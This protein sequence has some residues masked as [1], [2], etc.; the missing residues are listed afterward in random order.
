MD[1][2]LAQRM[3]PQTINEVLGQQTLI[4]PHGFLRRCI[5]TDSLVSMVLYGPSGTGKTTIAK[6]LGNDMKMPVIALNA[7][8]TSKADMV[9]A[10]QQAADNFP[11]MVIIDEIHRLPKDKQDLLLPYLESGDFFMVGTTTANPYISLNPAL[12]SR[13]QILEVKPLSP[14][15]ILTGLKRA[16]ASPVGLKNNRKFDEQ[17]LIS[18]AKM[19]GGDLRFAYNLLETLALYYPAGHLITED[20]LKSVRSVPNFLSDKDED[21]HYN[22]VSGLQKS[23]RGSQVDAALFYLAKLLQGGDLEG[24]IRRLLV[25]AYEDVG[26]ANPQAV[27]RCYHACQVAR[28]VGMPEAQIPL[29]FTVVDLALSPKS[30]SSCLAIETAMSTITDAPV[31]VREY[32]KLHPVGLSKA[33][34]YPYDRPD[35]WPKLEYMPEGMENVHFY[36]PNLSGKYERALAQHLK[37]LETTKRSTDLAE[38]K[39]EK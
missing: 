26:L 5:E 14:E 37:E 28:E 25:T 13:A 39:R 33:D 32:L 4:G 16:I 8:L 17:T 23:I 35:V 7:V 20:D 38:L 21:E 3:R 24:L 31:H 34:S 12:R 11:T 18:I 10:F 30:K 1:R 15:D 36:H 9:K 22:T 27:D 29:G 6:A 2:P 19:S